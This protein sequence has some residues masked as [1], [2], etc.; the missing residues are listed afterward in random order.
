MVSPCYLYIKCDKFGDN[1]WTS[2]NVSSCGKPSS[3]SDGHISFLLWYAC[4]SIINE[5][6]DRQKESDNLQLAHT[7]NK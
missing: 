4:V 7:K 5:G 6:I 2:R 1:R 3:H